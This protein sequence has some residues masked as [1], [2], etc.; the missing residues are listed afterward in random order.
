MIPTQQHARKVNCYFSSIFF[1]LVFLQYDWQWRDVSKK[2]DD[3]LFLK[4]SFR[5]VTSKS[6]FFLLLL[7]FCRQFLYIQIV[8]VSRSS[9]KYLDAMT[10]NSTASGR[11][12]TATDEL[13]YVWMI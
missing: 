13:L 5:D 3:Y 8:I 1:F 7:F 6:C 11:T 12:N 2:D 4:S 9:N 10:N